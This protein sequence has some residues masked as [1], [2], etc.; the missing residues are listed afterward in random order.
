MQSKKYQV[1]TLEILFAL[2]NKTEPGHRTRAT[3]QPQRPGAQGRGRGVLEGQGWVQRW[4]RSALEKAVSEPC[5]QLQSLIIHGLWI[6]EFAC[7]L[8]TYL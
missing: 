8:K 7:S 3:G 6:C 2:G 5:L 4:G 1:P